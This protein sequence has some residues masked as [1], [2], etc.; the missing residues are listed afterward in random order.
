MSGALDVK[1]HV[2]GSSQLTLEHALEQLE[3]LLT[4]HYVLSKRAIA[5]L[6]LQEDEQVRDLVRSR[7]ANV[8]LQ[9]EQINRTARILL[10]AGK[11][12][13]FPIR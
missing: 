3:N 10:K 2:T 6:L 4:G 12:R 13:L 1:M 5:L 7:D 9:V 11:G 8:C